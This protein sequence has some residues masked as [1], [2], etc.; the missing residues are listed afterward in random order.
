MLVIAQLSVGETKTGYSVSFETVPT[1]LN[2]IWIGIGSVKSGPFQPEIVF[3]LV[4]NG[5][6]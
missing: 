5:L 2:Q 3:G 4:C 6:S 1:F